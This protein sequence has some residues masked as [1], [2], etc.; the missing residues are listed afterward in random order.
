MSIPQAGN[1][2]RSRERNFADR[3][4]VFREEKGWSQDALAR[5]CVDLGL[6]YMNQS[7]IS[8][9]EKGTRAVRLDEGQVLASVFDMTIGVMLEPSAIARGLTMAD[10]AIATFES[11]RQQVRQTSRGLLR[12]RVIFRRLLGQIVALRNEDPDP[13]ALQAIE[14]RVSE[15][16]RALAFDFV[17]EFSDELGGSQ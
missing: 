16:Q 2:S 8:R 17:K 13:E 12:T 5:K 6:E 9:I 11:Q 10:S 1:R 3:V 7:T 15:L 4:K 14:L